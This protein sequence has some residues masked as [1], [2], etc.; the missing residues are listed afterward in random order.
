MAFCATCGSPVEGRFCSKCGS[1]AAAG[2]AGAAPA[3]SAPIAQSAPL[4]DNVASAMT[5]IFPVNLVFLSLAPYSRNPV[6]RFH[7]F[8][9][10]FFDLVC[11]A[12]WFGLDIVIGMIA[13]IVGYW[14][15]SPLYG[16]MQLALFVG[17]LCIVVQVFQGKTVV[18]PVL[19]QL[20]QQQSRV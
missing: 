7:A 8:Q 16:L 11:L 10:I 12:L 19:G 6:V 17:W 15:Y 1:A 20:A 2:A 5:Y 18:L 14:L 9:S 3:P 13:R 4:P